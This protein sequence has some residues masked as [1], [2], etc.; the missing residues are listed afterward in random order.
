MM[1]AKKKKILKNTYTANE[2][3]ELLGIGAAWVY[4]L[5]DNGTLTEVSTRKGK[6]RLVDAGSIE[7]YDKWREEKKLK[8]VPKTT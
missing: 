4:M 7:R 5:L 6:V 3:A 1:K 2:A 8:K